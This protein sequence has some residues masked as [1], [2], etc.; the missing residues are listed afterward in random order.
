MFLWVTD[1]VF[2]EYFMGFLLPSSTYDYIKCEYM[3]LQRMLVLSKEM[4][5][6]VLWE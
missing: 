2:V 5:L 3:K 6:F 1:D 4:L